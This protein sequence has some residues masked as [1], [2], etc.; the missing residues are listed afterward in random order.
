MI[1]GD[2]A[3]HLLGQPLLVHG[4]GILDGEIEPPA[5]FPY[6]T[7]GD[8]KRNKRTHDVHGRMHPHEPP[9]PFNID[10]RGHLRARR[11]QGGAFRRHM[12]DLARFAIL[13]RGGNG[14]LA[15]IRQDEHA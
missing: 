15:A 13:H 3:V 1:L 4:R 5:V 11:G 2:D 7:A 10:A 9:S 8:G 14:N 6:L 12:H